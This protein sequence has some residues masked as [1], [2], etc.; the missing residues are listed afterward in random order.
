VV[1]NAHRHSEAT[2]QNGVP[3]PIRGRDVDFAVTLPDFLAFASIPW[4]YLILLI[5]VPM[6]GFDGRA[7]DPVTLLALGL[8]WPT[9]ADPW[10][11]MQLG[12]TWLVPLVILHPRFPIRGF[13][14]KIL[15]L[16]VPFW[17]VLALSWGRVCDSFQIPRMATSKVFFVETEK[18]APLEGRMLFG[19]NGAII[20]FNP[21]SKQMPDSK[22]IVIPHE[23]LQKIE[24]IHPTA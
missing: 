15:F 20:L 12:L 9:A 19:L 7:V 3:G 17:L 14:Q 2:V 11:L 1:R 21:A 8:T 6:F 24:T 16:A 18:V 5:G 10:T 4:T 22:L 13:V 23:K